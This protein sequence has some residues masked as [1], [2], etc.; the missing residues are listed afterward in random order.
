L[1]ITYIEGSVR[2]PLGEGVLPNRQRRNLTGKVWRKIGLK[3]VREHE[4]ILMDG[5]VID[6]KVFRGLSIS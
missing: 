6:R 5:M 1:G 2:G 4:F 3:L